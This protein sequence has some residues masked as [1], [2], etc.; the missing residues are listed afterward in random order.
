MLQ[1]FTD[2]RFKIANTEGL[3]VK[4]LVILACLNLII[5][6]LADNKIAADFQ[7]DALTQVYWDFYG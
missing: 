2:L 5:E 6:I 4:K 7:M 1:E 3:G